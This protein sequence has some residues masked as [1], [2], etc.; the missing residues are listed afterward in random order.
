MMKYH[1]EQY[2]DKCRPKS[3]SMPYIAKPSKPFNLS[4][5]AGDL[6]QILS[7]K[8][9]LHKKN[10]TSVPNDHPLS[11]IP[12][13]Q[14]AVRGGDLADSQNADSL[15]AHGRRARA[16][17]R[18]GKWKWRYCASVALQLHADGPHRSHAYTGWATHT[19]DGPRLLDC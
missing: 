11:V 4:C 14:C 19:S 18:D 7:L 6:K 17:H 3:F 5:N 1:Q 10:C 2:Q 13:A 9:L 8:K 16:K 12:S 15:A